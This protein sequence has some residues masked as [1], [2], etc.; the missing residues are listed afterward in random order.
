MSVGVFGFVPER[1]TQA[2]LGRGFT[3]TELE[4]RTGITRQS[5]SAYESGT[6]VPIPEYLERLAKELRFPVG[7][8][9]KPLQPHFKNRPPLFRMLRSVGQKDKDRV[10]SHIEWLAETNDYALSFVDL[11][12]VNVPEELLALMP[13]DPKQLEDDLIT[14]AA[15]TLREH[16]GLRRSP[17]PNLLRLLER[18]GFVVSLLHL[19]VPGVDGLSMWSDKHRIPY[20]LLNRDKGSMVRFRLTLCHELGHLILHNRYSKKSAESEDI[21]KILDEQAYS[22]GR[23][24]LLP[25]DSFLEDVYSASLD[26]LVRL[27]PKWK[28]A[29]SAMVYRLH[30]LGVIPESKYRSLMTEISKKKW[31]SKEPFDDEWEPEQP[32]LLR[33]ALQ[34]IVDNGIQEANKLEYDTHIDTQLIKRL[35]NL[36]DDFF[37]TSNYDNIIK[38]SSLG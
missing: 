23:A 14:H 29:I 38:L 25:A 36:P 18:N 1:L 3:M 11:P 2:R 17:V 24:F 6:S 9:A 7:F 19:E 21:S 16:W 22:F 28:V 10:V 15:D 35:T 33:Q 32:I 26:C 5:L 30:S 20:I 8:F 27:K 13:A 37:V 34:V 31:K 4:E 12:E